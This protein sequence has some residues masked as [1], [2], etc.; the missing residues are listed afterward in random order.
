MLRWS[1]RTLLFSFRSDGVPT[2]D[3]AKTMKTGSIGLWVHSVNGD[4]TRPVTT[5]EDLD[6]S[7]VDRTLG[8]SVWSL[9]P[10]RLVSRNRLDLILLS[11]FVTGGA[12]YIPFLLY[13]A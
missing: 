5:P 13:T 4:R 3:R 6:L 2:S 10:V 9:P 1:D 12:P 7:G 11:L 8:G